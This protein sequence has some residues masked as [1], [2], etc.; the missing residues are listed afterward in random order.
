MSPTPRETRLA[1]NEA[2][3]R[4]ANERMAKWEERHDAR[5]KELYLCECADPTCR[6]KLALTL[7]Q[8]EHV[9]AHSR[10][11]AVRN[12]HETPDVEVVVEEVGDWSIVEKPQD[13][14]PVLNGPEPGPD[15][16]PAD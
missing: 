2:L 11:F 6:D 13:T 10:H 3:F 7:E 9:R 1:K 4:A 15:S 8:Y 14:E 12:G 16:L 5:E